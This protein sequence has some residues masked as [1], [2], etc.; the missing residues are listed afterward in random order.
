M[1]LFRGTNRLKRNARSSGGLSFA[2]SASPFPFP[3]FGAGKT[4]FGIFI[5]SAFFFGTAVIVEHL[6]DRQN[7]TENMEAR[8]VAPVVPVDEPL[9]P[10]MFNPDAQWGDARRFLPVSSGTDSPLSDPFWNAFVES[11]IKSVRRSDGTPSIIER[12]LPKDV[13]EDSAMRIFSVYSYIR[14]VNPS[15][16]AVVALVEAC[17]MEIYSRETNLPLS[18]VV[19][20]SQTESNFRPNAV[21]NMKARG[22]MQVMWKY[23]YGVLR[24]NGIMEEK[25][26]NDPEMGIAAGTIVLSRYLRAEQSI[27]GALAR[28]Y[29]KLEN[30]YVGITLSHKHAF[31]LYESGISDSWKNSMARERY[32]W[33]RMTG[34]R[35]A[36]SAKKAPPL[37]GEAGNVGPSVVVSVT[38][39]QKS[40][41]AKST[42]SRKPDSPAPSGSLVRASSHSSG[43]FMPGGNSI[44]VVYK[45]GDRK[46]W[47]D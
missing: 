35:E 6:V 16:D 41:S 39:S 32:F 44:T 37:P 8:A 24:A 11:A 5:L 10:A 29:G 40:T 23:H 13:S 46:S 18:L 30:K 9:P 25:H 45:N 19:G 12:A 1:G 33:N 38:P 15:I 21:S 26:L 17:S 42:V 20:V 43:T 14:D 22:P 34:G 36:L 7:K 31:E 47:K 4:V 27:P 28:Y 3:G 2:P